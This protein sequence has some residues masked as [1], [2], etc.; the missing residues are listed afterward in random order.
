MCVCVCVALCMS[1][2][3]T[4]RPAA[5]AQ[6][7]SGQ[8]VEGL[9]SVDWDEERKETLENTLHTSNQGVYCVSETVS[10]ETIHRVKLT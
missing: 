10:N 7:Y 8:F 6:I 9:N 1:C 3:S 4:F 2:F 5:V